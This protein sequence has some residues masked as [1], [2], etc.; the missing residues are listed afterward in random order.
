MITF[1][2]L[3]DSYY[4]DKGLTLYRSLENCTENF[5]LYIFCFDDVSYNTLNDLN[6]K[7]AIVIHHS[8]I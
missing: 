3:F 5:K 8:E 7:H 1:C 4:L 6:L 2:T